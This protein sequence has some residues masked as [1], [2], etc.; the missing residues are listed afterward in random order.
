MSLQELTDEDFNSVITQSDL[1]VVVDFW[2]EWCSP[3]RKVSP[4]MEQL[5][6]ELT[7][8]ALVVKV[9]VDEAVT[10]GLQQKVMGLP[11]VAVFKDGKR[12]IEMSG[13]HSKGDFLKMIEVAL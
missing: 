12:V 6:E 7:G 4:L 8:K 1:P 5:A 2:A 11:T 13:V 3:C 10:T 9:N